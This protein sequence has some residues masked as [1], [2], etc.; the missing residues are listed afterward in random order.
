ME[1]QALVHIMARDGARGTR[2]LGAAAA[3]AARSDPQVRLHF[4]IHVHH[5]RRLASVGR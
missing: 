3:Y 1:M 2:G 4:P 5:P